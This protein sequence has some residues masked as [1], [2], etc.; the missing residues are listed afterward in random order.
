MS[1]ICR[2]A[3]AP[4][5]PSALCPNAGLASGQRPR[6]IQAVIV[7]SSRKEATA[8]NRTESPFFAWVKRSLEYRHLP[9]ILALG[10]AL[11]SL[12]SLKTGLFADDL[13]QRAIEFPP[14][15]LPPRMTDAGNPAN[16]GSF[17]TVLFDLFGLNRDPQ[18][19][20]RMKNYGAVP[21]GGRRMT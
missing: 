13:P 7:D 3:F 14:S 17:S 16:S 4:R 12:P 19:L 8:A 9:A 15:Q 18:C 5:L 20:A 10:A 1:E 21:C 6:I 11:I 2:T